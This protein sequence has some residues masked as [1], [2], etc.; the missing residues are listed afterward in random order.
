L[1][2]TP[3]WS[4]A[5]E[6]EALVRAPPRGR[7]ARL[8]APLPAA[9]ACPACR[10]ARLRGARAARLRA[11]RTARPRLTLGCHPACR[12]RAQAA[13]L[14]AA[15][16]APPYW[17]QLAHVL[18]TMNTAGLRKKSMI[19][20]AREWGFRCDVW[21]RKGAGRDEEASRDAL[22]GE[23]AAPR[24]AQRDGAADEAEPPAPASKRR[25]SAPARASAAAPRA[26][27]AAPRAAVDDDGDD[28]DDALELIASADAPQ[29]ADALQLSS[30]AD[31]AAA[32]HRLP[33]GIVFALAQQQPGP[34]ALQALRSLV[35]NAFTPLASSAAAQY[36]GE[37]ALQA[38][39]A[40]P[41][42]QCDLALPDRLADNTR[43]LHVAQ[44]L[45]AFLARQTAV[46]RDWRA[47]RAC[48]APE[49]RAVEAW[50]ALRACES[51]VE[52]AL[53]VLSETFAAGEEDSRRLRAQM[54]ARAPLSPAALAWFSGMDEGI[55]DSMRWMAHAQ[56]AAAQM[57]LAPLDA[58]LEASE[59]LL[60]FASAFMMNVSTA[61][62]R[63]R[64]WMLELA[65]GRVAAPVG[66][67][68][69]P[70]LTRVTSMRGYPADEA[71]AA[72]VAPA[73]C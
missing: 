16:A 48:G 57:R 34:G 70:T 50:D 35:Q 51:P 10:C 17:L 72:Q 63:R 18:R 27:A 29:H 9:P 23:P 45:L 43:L 67:S 7:L 28:W 69:F 68:S 71:G 12:A 19:H 22:A 49:E 14:C 6:R 15:P 55:R 30:C 62:A 8:R 47:Q 20:L 73:L 54:R 39:L 33:A 2:R 40:A 25:R 32:S 38:A 66:L 41:R 3:Q 44:W 42:A 24:R 37:R 26:S 65:P 31:P 13:R 61:F 64:Q 21:C 5:N 46:T 56:A 58:Y 53:R 52:A 59:L 4:N 36:V 1:A 11:A 60:R